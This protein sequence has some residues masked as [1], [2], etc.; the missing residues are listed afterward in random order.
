MENKISSYNFFELR[1]IFYS[2]TEDMFSRWRFRMKSHKKIM[3]N[4]FEDLLDSWI[5]LLRFGRLFILKPWHGKIFL[6]IIKNGIQAQIL[7]CNL[8]PRDVKPTQ[9]CT[10]MTL[11]RCRLFIDLVAT[12][13]EIHTSWRSFSIKMCLKTQNTHNVTY[14]SDWKI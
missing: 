10:H 11:N 7:L 6:P 9:G 1:L 8:L 4:A 3:R 13:A 2:A 5:I 14:L 12:D